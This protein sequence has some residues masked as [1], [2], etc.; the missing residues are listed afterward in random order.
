MGIKLIIFKNKDYYRLS[1]T[2]LSSI[3]HDSGSVGNWMHPKEKH[4]KWERFDY[5]FMSLCIEAGLTVSIRKPTD[6]EIEIYDSKLIAIQNEHGEPVVDNT[7]GKLPILEI[8]DNYG[9][10]GLIKKLVLDI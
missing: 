8:A 2:A 6:K 5:G 3:V 4:N 1:K 7:F 9:V 10:G